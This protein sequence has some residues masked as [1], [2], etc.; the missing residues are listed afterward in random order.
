MKVVA[1]TGEN[2]LCSYFSYLEHTP[3]ATKMT[4]QTLW[5]LSCASLN[6][7]MWQSSYQPITLL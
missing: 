1:L 3:A 6:H 7:W 4:F 5:S 2:I